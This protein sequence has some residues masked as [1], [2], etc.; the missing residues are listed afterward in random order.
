MDIGEVSGHV[1]SGFG[2]GCSALIEGCSD[3]LTRGRRLGSV[4]QRCNV[5]CSAA[6]EVS[7]RSMFSSVSFPP[8][9]FSLSRGVR[10]FRDFFGKESSMFTQQ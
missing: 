6:G 8:M 9:C 5:T 10:L 4:L 1:V 7:R 3:L 2:R